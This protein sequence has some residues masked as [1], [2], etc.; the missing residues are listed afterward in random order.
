MKSMILKIFNTDTIPVLGGAGGAI[1]S[2][3]FQWPH[4]DTLVAVII[5]AVVGGIVGYF[6]KLGL[7][8]VIKKYKKKWGK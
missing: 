2:D 5:F 7:D 3:T 1:A 4:V 8:W 6:V